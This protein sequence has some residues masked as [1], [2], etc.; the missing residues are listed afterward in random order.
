MESTHRKSTYRGTI[1]L[2]SLLR[3]TL[4]GDELVPPA[5]VIKQRYDGWLRQQE[6]AGVHFTDEQRWW[7][8]ELAQAVATSAHID[9]R[10]LDGPPFASRGGLD[11]ATTAFG[12]KDLTIYLRDLNVRLAG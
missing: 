4:V 9:L 3:H 6:Q 5:D 12:G 10:T 2:V 1:D 11:G 7:L 8:D